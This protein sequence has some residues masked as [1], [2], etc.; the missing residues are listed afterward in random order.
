MVV[1][2]GSVAYPITIQITQDA[3][4]AADLDVQ[5]GVQSILDLNPIPILSSSSRKASG[6]K[7]EGKGMEFHTSTNKRLQAPGDTVKSK[8]M[9]FDRY[10][11][12]WGH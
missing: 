6:I 7:Q 8:T 3:W 4:D 11:K 2:S 5:R 10:G 9:T 1:G 12:G